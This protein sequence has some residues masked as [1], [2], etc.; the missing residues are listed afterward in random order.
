MELPDWL[1]PGSPTPFEMGLRGISDALDE[2]YG[3]MV[4]GPLI[5][6]GGQAAGGGGPQYHLHVHS[7]AP[8]EPVIAD[9]RMMEAMGA[10]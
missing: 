8:T 5:G 10:R 2:L 3:Q 9:F 7:S 1:K 6:V 4:S